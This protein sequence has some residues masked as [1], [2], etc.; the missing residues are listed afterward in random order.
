MSTLPRARVNSAPEIRSKPTQSQQTN[1]VSSLSSSSSNLHL[2]RT[3]S[4]SPFVCQL[5]APAPLR[6]RNGYPIQER[7]PR[8]ILKQPPA[9]NFQPS[10]LAN[11]SMTWEEIPMEES[12][13]HD[14]PLPY[15][16]PARSSR[17]GNVSTSSPTLFTLKGPDTPSERRKPSQIY[18]DDE[19]GFYCFGRCFWFTD[20]FTSPPSRG[21]PNNLLEGNRFSSYYLPRALS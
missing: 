13:P 9:T 15:P 18:D 4:N 1:L 17:Y 16:Y 20:F 8:K 12:I 5:Q 21:T 11:S 10:P 19:S 6:T 2:P 14:D 7:H 3:I